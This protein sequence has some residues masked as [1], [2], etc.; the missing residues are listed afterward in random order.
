ML[1]LEGLKSSSNESSYREYRLQVSPFL[2]PHPPPALLLLI[3]P[4]LTH[5]APALAPEQV[6][7]RLFRFNYEI[8]A[9]LE[10]DERRQKLGE[11]YRNVEEDYKRILGS[12]REE[13]LWDWVMRP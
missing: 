13:R 4:F 9:Q 11:T 12:V 3:S 1:L 6:K 2:P 7:E 8:L 5:P 10:P